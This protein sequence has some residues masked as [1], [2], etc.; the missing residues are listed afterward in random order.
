[1]PPK[2]FEQITVRVTYAA[3]EKGKISVKGILV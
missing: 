3:T 1:M 2:L